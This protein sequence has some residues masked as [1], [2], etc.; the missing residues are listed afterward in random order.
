[1]ATISD[2]S[3]DLGLQQAIQKR[4][5]DDAASAVVLDCRNGEIMA[6]VSNPSYDP[7]LF[8]TGVSQAQWKEWTKDRRTPADQQGDLRACTHP[9]RPSKWRWRWPGSTR[10]QSPP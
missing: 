5:G 3:F 10:R 7:T 6:M 9:G 2:L 1:M 8:A 4:L